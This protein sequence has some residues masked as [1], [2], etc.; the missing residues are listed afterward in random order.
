MFMYDDHFFMFIILKIKDWL[1]CEE[2]ITGARFEHLGQKFFY[3]YLLEDEQDLSVGEMLTV[4][5]GTSNMFITLWFRFD[6]GTN[7]P[8]GTLM[9]QQVHLCMCI[10]MCYVFAGKHG[11]KGRSH[12]FK[13][14]IEESHSCLRAWWNHSKRWQGRKCY[15]GTSPRIEA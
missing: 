15:K 12:K 7:P 9:T 14:A 4:Y 6:Y 13:G 2:R 1:T 8:P 5:F 10:R 11:H 3:D